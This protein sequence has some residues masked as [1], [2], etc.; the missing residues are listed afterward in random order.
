MARIKAVA[1][2]ACADSALTLEQPA[3]QI[4]SFSGWRFDTQKRELLSPYQ[5]V[6]TLSSA[7]YRLLMAF[8]DHPRRVLSRG[9][10]LDLTRGASLIFNERA[11]DLAVSRL[12]QKLGH[13]HEPARF[14]AT[15]RGEGYV[16][17][18]EPAG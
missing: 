13:A 6:L 4:R 9:R 17:D 11:I 3:A 8:F 14:I 15:V 12:R 10:L 7:E 1:R 2:R 18:P 5:A 16:F